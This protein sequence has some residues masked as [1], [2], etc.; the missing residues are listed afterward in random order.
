[1][2]VLIRALSPTERYP[3]LQDTI[4]I[5]SVNKAVH[6]KALGPWQILPARIMAEVTAA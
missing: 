1:M 2:I 6:R 4:R 5:A 3:Q